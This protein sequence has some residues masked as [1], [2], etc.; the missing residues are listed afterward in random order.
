MWSETIDLKIRPVSD[1]KKIGRDLGLA[2]DGLRLV[3]LVL[4]LSIW[5]CLHH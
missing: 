5:S 3:I 1:Q 2:L 4:V